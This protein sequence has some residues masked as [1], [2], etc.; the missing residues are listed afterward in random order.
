MLGK[1]LIRCF[2]SAV[3]DSR[4]GRESSLYT[5]QPLCCPSEAQSTQWMLKSLPAEF[6]DM[7][8]ACL[9]GKCQRPPC[10]ILCKTG[11]CGD[12]SKKYCL[13]LSEEERRQWNFLHGA[14]TVS[15][16]P[17]KQLGETAQKSFCEN[18]LSSLWGKFQQKKFLYTFTFSGLG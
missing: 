12:I 5:F 10:R 16:A 13:R 9:Q 1:I 3:G 6:H 14:G 18:L 7:L 15:R 17:Q 8:G 2:H 4:K 11:H